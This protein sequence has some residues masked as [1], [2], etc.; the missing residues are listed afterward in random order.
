MSVENEST[1][2]STCDVIERVIVK[3]LGEEGINVSAIGHDDLLFELGIDSM[4]AGLVIG[5]LEE[6]FH[7]TIKPEDMFELETIQEMA[8]HL[9]RLPR[10]TAPTKAASTSEKPVPVAQADSAMVDTD[11]GL[12]K[13]DHGGDQVPAGWR[14]GCPGAGG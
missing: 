2:L 1:P 3:R 13:I 4:I 5:D 14:Q 7:K 10:L 8:E 11:P 9:D 6:K 12:V